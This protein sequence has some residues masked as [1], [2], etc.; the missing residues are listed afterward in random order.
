MSFIGK[1][2]DYHKDKKDLQWFDI[3]TKLY[4]ISDYFI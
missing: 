4:E 3:N 1:I 2:I